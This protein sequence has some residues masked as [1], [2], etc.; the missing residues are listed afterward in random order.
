MLQTSRTPGPRYWPRAGLPETGVEESFGFF[1]SLKSEDFRH[2]AGLADTEPG[3]LLRRIFTANADSPVPKSLC[4]NSFILLSDYTV[5]WGSGFYY[6]QEKI[7]NQT[8]TYQ[9]YRRKHFKKLIRLPVHCLM[10]DLKLSKEPGTC[11]SA[12]DAEE[13][14]IQKMPIADSAVRRYLMTSLSASLLP[15]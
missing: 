13:L 12:P 8:L 5:P 1:S 2:H 6:H 9:N 11:R 4:R 14:P 15:L 3:A 7:P 10:A